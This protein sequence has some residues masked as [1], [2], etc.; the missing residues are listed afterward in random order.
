MAMH[1]VMPRFSPGGKGPFMHYLDLF[2]YGSMKFETSGV[3]FVREAEADSTNFWFVRKS[4]TKSGETQARNPEESGGWLLEIVDGV[5]FGHFVFC[6]LERLPFVFGTVRSRRNPEP[7]S[8]LLEK[9]FRRNPACS[10][11]FPAS[12]AMIPASLGLGAYSPQAGRRTLKT[13]NL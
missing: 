13:E 3:H 9:G 11:A 1:V 4:V 10:G 12:L 8:A 5:G 2:V 7:K 6:C